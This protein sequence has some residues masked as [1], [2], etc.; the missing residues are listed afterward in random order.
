[1]NLSLRLANFI[2]G[3]EK[4]SA[5]ARVKNPPRSATLVP[6]LVVSIEV[7]KL[8]LEPKKKSALQNLL[9]FQSRYNVRRLCRWHLCCCNGY[10]FDQPYKVCT[11]NWYY[12]THFKLS[13]SI[14]R[15]RHNRQNDTNTATNFPLPTFGVCRS[16][17]GAKEN[18]QDPNC[19][20]KLREGWRL[21]WQ[22]WIV[23]LLPIN[24]PLTAFNWSRVRFLLSNTTVFHWGGWNQV[25]FQ[26]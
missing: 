14:L 25:S 3:T 17:L 6:C 16:R 1:M 24:R 13:D 23:P 10:R 15:Y 21:P 4:K 5:A 9:S 20:C 7:A 22:G 2:T 26:H 18:A 11:R 12:Y 19:S 8:Y